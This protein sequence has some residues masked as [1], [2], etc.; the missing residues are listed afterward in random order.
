M[1]PYILRPERFKIRK[2]NFSSNHLVSILRTS[3]Q[4]YLER[5][6]LIFLFV[7]LF[8]L[9]G[10]GLPGL[11]A[12]GLNDPAISK[13]GFGPFFSVVRV[14][15][16]YYREFQ[17]VGPF[18]FHESSEKGNAFG[19][20]PLF[21]RRN[22]KGNTRWDLLY[23]LGKYEK[24][25]GRN[26]SYFALFFRSDTYKKRGEEKFTFF[27][28]FWG[29]TS[30]GKEYGGIFPIYGHLINRFERKDIRFFLWPLYSRSERRDGFI[31]TSTPWPFIATFS[32]KKGEGFRFWP[33]FGHEV[34]SGVYQKDFLLWPFFYHTKLDKDKYPVERW[35][36][37][38]FYGQRERLPYYHQTDL[39][40]PIFRT[41]R[42]DKNHY[43]RRDAWPVFTKARG[44]NI[45]W[46]RVFPFYVH[47]K[48]G[49]DEK[50]VWLW[51][52]Y[53]NK[54]Y[55]E[56]KTEIDNTH[57]MIWSRFL[58]KREP[59][60]SWGIVRQ[61]MWPLFND[62]QT[63]NERTWAAPDPIP[64]VYEG[65]IRNWRPIWTFAGGSESG[66]IH[67]TRILW[68]LFDRIQV[69]NSS[70]TD[71]AGLVQWEQEG[72]DTHR[73]SLLQGLIKYEN[74]RGHASLRLFFLPWRLRW[75]ATEYTGWLEEETWGLR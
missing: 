20:R 70:L 15:S 44:D 9:F 30:K 49:R 59:G 2:S 19:L 71:I 55:W 47:R 10:P 74:M 41:I 7:S 5:R 4:L 6:L 33:L 18:I 48:R 36:F 11:E 16:P 29:K 12:S 13:Y 52:F 54:H 25:K 1:P 50:R 34:K 73:F 35:F 66:G 60:K 72:K 45:D 75:H 26:K 46:L 56:G 39:L 37:F 58:H 31:R 67:R 38:P 40:W 8:F 14:K 62:A 63:R 24:T 51:P 32:G 43:I 42:N 27:P 57:F 53:K 17:A 3:R 23:P 61:G 22:G 68:G 28:F 69:K 21:S 64:I 65:Y